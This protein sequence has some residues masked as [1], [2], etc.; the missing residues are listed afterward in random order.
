MGVVGPFPLERPRWHDVAPVNEHLAEVL[1]VPT[2]VLRLV[3]VAGG[4][5]GRGGLVTYHA[6]ALALPAVE[7]AA[8]AEADPAGLRPHPL[9]A[10]YATADGVRAALEW[11]EQ[12]LAAAGR[13]VTGPVA[14][15]KT[16]NLAGLFRLPTAEGPVWLK[17]GRD[18][19]VDESL[20][21]Q[22]LGGVDPQF[23]PT[24]LAAD[25]Q[26]R[27]LL[28]DHVPGE[29]CWGPS[30]EV[31]AATLPRLARAQAALAASYP[32]GA[33]DGLAD[34]SPATLVP[35][36][37]LLLDGEAGAELTAEELDR[38]RALVERLPELVEQ[39]AACGLPLTVVHGDFHPGNWRSAGRQSVLVDF[40]D[41]YWGHPAFDGLRPADFLN[42]ERWAE[43]AELWC[44]AWRTLAPGSD[45]AGA[46]RLA[47]PLSHL[48]YAV[49]Y[50]E[51][52]DAIEPSERRYH[53]GDPA[54]EL[55]AALSAAAAL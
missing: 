37:K 22:L 31:V 10:G 3:D 16:W 7:L 30:R 53:E 12:A 44:E 51:F 27:L 1:G 9:R 35:A 21:V 36:V 6:E 20:V 54:A 42:Q 48:A 39:L 13:P 38:A 50:Q 19:A 26:R 11:A 43:A 47:A 5:S 40:A 17:T 49:R 2:V 52:L 8:P 28:M 25:P 23:V 4:G 45:P 18:F 15:M 24:V 46:L 41:A 14:Q 29:D 33:P 32:G 55:R 34:R